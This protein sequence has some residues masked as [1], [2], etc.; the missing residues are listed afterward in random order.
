MQKKTTRGSKNLQFLSRVFTGQLAKPFMRSLTRRRF[1]SCVDR[2]GSH[3]IHTFSFIYFLVSEPFDHYE[4]KI[5]L[6][7]GTCINNYTASQRI[8]YWNENTIL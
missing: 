2:I 3:S 6:H 5:L 7:A 1:S 8:R 4:I